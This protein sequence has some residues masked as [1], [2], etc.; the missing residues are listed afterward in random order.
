MN[1][2]ILLKWPYQDWTSLCRVLK[3]V[4]SWQRK[5]FKS[6]F[7]HQKTQNWDQIMAK[8]DVKH[9]F[10]RLSIL[11]IRG[12]A[13]LLVNRVPTANPPRSPGW[14]YPIVKWHLFVLLICTLLLWFHVLVPFCSL[15]SETV[16]LQHFFL[17]GTSPF[18]DMCFLGWINTYY[19]YM[20]MSNKA[21]RT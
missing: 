4:L 6:F 17:Y 2:G 20:P 8:L 12:N 16:F 1:V 9:L 18:S 14:W 19:Q 13:A 3:V 21:L 5:L 11:L 7:F 10:G 15:M